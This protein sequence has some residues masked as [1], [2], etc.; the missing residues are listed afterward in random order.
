MNFSS[1]RSGY[2]RLIKA[3]AAGLACVL[4]CFVPARAADLLYATGGGVGEL[5]ALYTLNTQTGTPTLLWNF[6]GVHIYG[7]GLAY[8]RASDSLFATGAWD[9]STGT[10]RLFSI[11]R[12]TGVLAEVGPVGNDLNLS[13]GGLAIHPLTGVMY[14]VGAGNQSTGLFTLSKTSGTATLVG[15]SGGQCCVVPFGFNMYGLGFAS[16]GTLFANGL[17]LSG[18]G[19]SHL[20]TLDLG[21]GLATDIGSHGVGVG[22]QLNYSGLAFDANG[23]MLSMGSYDAASG[24]LFT[25]NTATG[26]ATSL[27]APGPYGSGPIHFGVDGGLS[28]APSAAVPEPAQGA[29]LLAGLLSLMLKRWRAPRGGTALITVPI[30]ALTAALTTV[31]M[32]FSALPAHADPG[33]PLPCNGN[34]GVG[35]CAPYTQIFYATDAANGN[36]FEYQPMP[37]NY[38]HSDVFGDLRG[39]ASLPTGELKVFGRTNNDGN[40]STAHGLIVSVGASDVFTLHSALAPGTPVQFGIVLTADGVG[41][42]DT[43]GYASAAYIGFSGPSL[44]VLPGGGN[45]FDVQVY[46]AGQNVPVFTDFPIHLFASA[47]ARMP[48]NEP[49][50]IDTYLR[51]N[52]TEAAY[53]DLS[54]TARLRFLLP[55]GVTISSM[56][57]YTA[58]VPE[59]GSA[60]LWLA[61]LAAMLGLQARRRMR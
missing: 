3:A 35:G 27:T 45:P 1:I 55:A 4:T 40:P 59:P 61:G 39:Q 60:A 6:P 10:T 43:D 49:F 23:V 2:R 5:S 26:A 18:D 7:G 13:A 22:R 29:L 38:V 21:S 50:Q 44:G 8:D 47:N 11:N 15:L 54:H 33:P 9:S 28:F 48:V 14:A 34:F 53:M 58:A 51:A 57:G 16:N 31:V 32:L 12:F 41:G 52:V 25:V 19:S 24:A 37:M 17:T 36:L 46:Q 56:G 20:F 42:I 30:A